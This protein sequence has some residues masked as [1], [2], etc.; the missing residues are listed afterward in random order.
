M[1]QDE[2]NQDSFPD[3]REEQLYDNKQDFDEECLRERASDSVKYDLKIGLIKMACNRCIEKYDEA[4]DELLSDS[5]QH[6]ID[7]FKY[8]IGE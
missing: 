5:P 4:I 3:P 1:S 6:I 2:E 7:E 8:K